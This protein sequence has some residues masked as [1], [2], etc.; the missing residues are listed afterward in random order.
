MENLN[1]SAEFTVYSLTE[2]RIV[3]RLAKGLPI[4]I[5]DQ[6]KLTVM[7]ESGVLFL[8]VLKPETKLVSGEQR[9]IDIAETI[10]GRSFSINETPYVVLRPYQSYLLRKEGEKP[11]AEFAT[12]KSVANP[13]G[14]SLGARRVSSLLAVVTSSLAI[15][16]AFF[17]GFEESHS[18]SRTT[19][20]VALSAKPLFDFP[21]KLATPSFLDSIELD[22]ISN[23]FSEDD[24][25]ETD[26]RNA[27]AAVS[28]E[29]A[30]TKRGKPDSSVNA[31]KV[32]Y[33]PVVDDDPITL[34][35][36]TQS[37]VAEN[38][39]RGNSVAALG[40]ARK[41]K[42]DKLTAWIQNWQKLAETKSAID[43]E[44]AKLLG[45]TLDRCYRTFGMVC[46]EFSDFENFQKSAET[47]AKQAASS[48]SLDDEPAV[49]RGKLEFIEDV[50]PFIE[51][52]TAA[53]KEAFVEKVREKVLATSLLINYS[54]A[55]TVAK[56]KDLQ[57][58]APR[59]GNLYSEIA[60][61]I[62]EQY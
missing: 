45:A 61:I 1:T 58:V 9:I 52:R 46:K 28:V 31:P 6:V 30:I 57:K 44:G 12:P 11:S 55:E 59:D 43:T 29:S 40:I 39:K 41:A 24:G 47:L 16:A 42:N 33:G 4:I 25:V 22:D 18:A 2:K 62:N 36:E 35:L 21:Q 27:V 8:E 54:R 10:T 49:T 19:T 38:M 17:V 14:P 15:M 23:P 56:L 53:S 20:A 5:E 26:T 48:L 51:N 3:N 7:D 60:S 32:E 50:E 13:S 34:T 37:E